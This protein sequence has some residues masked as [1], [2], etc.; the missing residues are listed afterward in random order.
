M[1]WRLV[2]IIVVCG[3]LLPVGGADSISGIWGAWRIEDAS[4]TERFG[5]GDLAI[6]A[7]GHPYIA[8]TEIHED[9]ATALLRWK[10][11]P[12]WETREFAENAEAEAVAIDSLGRPHVLWTDL[13]FRITYTS[14][15]NGWQ[16]EPLGATWK[17]KLAVDDH[18]VPHA[19]VGQSGVGWLWKTRGPTG[20]WTSELITS[21]A[22]SVR[23]AAIGFAPNGEAIVMM[24]GPTSEGSPLYLYQR[25]A[26]SWTEVSVPCSGQRSDMAV[27]NVGRVHIVCELG[28][29]LAYARYSGGTWTSETVSQG[30]PWCPAIAVSPNGLPGIATIFGGAAGSH[31]GYWARAPTGWVQEIV[32][33]SL[34]VSRSCDLDVAVDS[35]GVPHIAYVQLGTIGVETRLPIVVRGQLQY[36]EPWAAFPQTLVGTNLP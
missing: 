6:D 29:N 8:A 1:S 2:A 15:A 28:G 24:P 12:L 32:D 16:S 3:S 14:E 19:V 5:L 10:T 13:D 35:E 9:S 11:G 23:Q 17:P 22:R 31:L 21:A 7:I 34:S 26:G 36:A 30:V 27:D 4:P 33:P 25:N 20:I 18:D